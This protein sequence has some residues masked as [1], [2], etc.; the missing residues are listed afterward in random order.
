MTNRSDRKVFL[1]VIDGGLLKPRSA[2]PNPNHNPSS[3]EM[4]Y[5]EN[6]RKMSEAYEQFLKVSG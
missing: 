2:K 3:P 4:S 6:L 5:L 1:S